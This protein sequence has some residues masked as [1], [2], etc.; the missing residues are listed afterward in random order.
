M[1]PCSA[2]IVTRNRCEEVCDAVSSALKQTCC[3]DIIVVVDASEDSTATTLKELFPDVR[4]LVNLERRGVSYSRNLAIREAK[5]E[6]ILQI[7]DDAILTSPDIAETIVQRFSCSESIAAV[8]IPYINVNQS[9][10]LHHQSPYPDEICV[11]YTYTGTAIMLR[12]STF[13]EL[14]GYSLELEHW[15]EER[16]YALRLLNAGYLVV[17]GESE[18]VHH[19]VSA[20]R[21]KIYQNIYLYRNQLFFNYLRAPTRYL[22]ALF[23][24]ALLWSIRNAFRS[25]TVWFALRG[26]LQG[27]TACFKYADSR[28]PMTISRY[29]LAL[30]LRRAG[31][32]PFSTVRDRMG[33]GV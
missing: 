15:G 1:T 23:I 19:L 31:G 4:I 18:P 6:F 24:W 26:F 17:Y 20:R 25:G 3:N 11:A 30:E 27:V 29:K 8:T 16:D 14:D 2:I 21:D 32:L 9:K 5:N 10:A 28:E 13:L 7:D 33:S 22:P 12:Q